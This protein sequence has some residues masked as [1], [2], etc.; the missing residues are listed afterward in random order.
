MTQQFTLSRHIAKLASLN[1]R[2]E[3]HGDENVPAA[4][5]KFEVTGHSTML[6][7]FGKDYRTFLF[8]KAAAGEQAALFPGDDLTQLS[9]PHLGPLKLD[10][11]FPGYTLRISAGLDTSDDIVIAD[12]SLSS[13]KFHPMNGGSVTI[14]FS[15]AAHP[16]EETVGWLYAQIQNDL[17][18]SLEPPTAESDRQQKIAA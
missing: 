3:K 15:V 17:E 7:A 1:P 13:W 2:A 18:I 9:K 5:L 12:V 14:A 6:D 4:D 8:R 16:D 11:E 10:E